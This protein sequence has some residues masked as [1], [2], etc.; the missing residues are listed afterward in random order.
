M[1]N[2]SD[3]VLYFL[4]QRLPQ[5]VGLCLMLLDVLYL[6]LAQLSG[7]R[8]RAL[9]FLSR[10]RHRTFLTITLTLGFAA[11][12]R[13]SDFLVCFCACV[14]KVEHTVNFLTHA[15]SQHGGLAVGEDERAERRCERVDFS[16]QGLFV[17]QLYAQAKYARL[18][19]GLEEVFHRSLFE[20]VGVHAG[21]HRLQQSV[22]VTHV[23][24]I[25]WGYISWLLQM[26]QLSVIAAAANAYHRV[27][28]WKLFSKREEGLV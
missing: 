2:L 24:R 4:E 13:L 20:L 23:V 10:R 8:G 12:S 14:V 26:A 1:R 17:E 25:F 19:K 28:I 22:Q 21:G 16:L 11:V 5:I 3:D 7:Y 18:S 15:V 27:L 9:H 6:R